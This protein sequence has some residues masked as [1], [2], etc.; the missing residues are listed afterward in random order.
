MSNKGH[1]FCTGVYRFVFDNNCKYR[2][3][4]FDLLQMVVARLCWIRSGTVCPVRLLRMTSFGRRAPEGFW[5]SAEATLTQVHSCSCTHTLGITTRSGRGKKPRRRNR[6]WDAL[7]R[8]SKLIICVGA[9]VIFTQEKMKCQF[10][11]NSHLV[12]TKYTSNQMCVTSE[13]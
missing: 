6:K 4:G 11:F 2:S 13:H 12:L 5:T 10:S 8:K 9:A 1:Y 7:W 3:L